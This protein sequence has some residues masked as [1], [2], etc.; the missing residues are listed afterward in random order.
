M[1][2]PWPVTAVD[3]EVAQVVAAMRNAGE[4]T[5]LEAFTSDTNQPVPQPEPLPVTADWFLANEPYGNGVT[6]R[7]WS[8][9]TRTDGSAC[10]AAFPASAGSPT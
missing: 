10:G 2:V 8:F 1:V 4:F 7:R 9:P 5:V 3:Q 6:P